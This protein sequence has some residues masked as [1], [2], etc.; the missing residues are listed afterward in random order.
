MRPDLAR[1]VAKSLEAT[2]ELLPYLSELLAD[3]DELGGSSQ[4][5]LTMLK[6]QRL[7]PGASVLDLGCG[8]GAIS[9]LLAEHLGVSVVG[10]DAFE[11]FIAHA[12]RLAQERSCGARCNFHCA[13]IRSLEPKQKKFDVVLFVGLGLRVAVQRKW[14]S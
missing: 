3:L 14:D 2:P 6:R 1:C 11:P 4:L 10:I 12:R 9:V 7:P 8:K 13:D 5:I